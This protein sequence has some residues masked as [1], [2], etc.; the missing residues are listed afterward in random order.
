MLPWNLTPGNNQILAWKF[1]AK[2]LYSRRF[3]WNK[4]VANFLHELFIFINE[5]FAII[6]D[7]WKRLIITVKFS[8]S[9]NCGSP[10]YNSDLR[11]T[12]YETLFWSRISVA[13]WL[14]PVKND[15]FK[16]SSTLGKCSVEFLLPI[17]IMLSLNN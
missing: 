1:I 17:V 5:K 3:A 11:V 10:G 7:D 8:I 13:A 4:C 14:F 15:R 6:V 12:T 2:G 16:S 9:D